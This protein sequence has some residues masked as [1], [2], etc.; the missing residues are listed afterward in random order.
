LIFLHSFDADL[1]EDR[2]IRKESNISVVVDQMVRNYRTFQSPL[3]FLDIFFSEHIIAIEVYSG[4]VMV[5][6]L[7]FAEFQVV[8]FVYFIVRGFAL[9]DKL[10]YILLH[11]VSYVGSEL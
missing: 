4:S 6:F 3:P 1:V 5:D 7:E 11:V 8:F 10:S 2:P 9:P